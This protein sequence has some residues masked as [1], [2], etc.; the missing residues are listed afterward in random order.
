MLIRASQSETVLYV[1]A[2]CSFEPN[3]SS[4]LDKFLA[5]GTCYINLLSP[6]LLNKVLPTTNDKNTILLAAFFYA[7]SS[8]SPGNNG[9]RVRDER[10]T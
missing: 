7:G 10:G 1:F 2:I 4:S 5:T 3:S 8:K 9:F 6:V